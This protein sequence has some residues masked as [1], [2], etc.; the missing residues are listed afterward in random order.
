[1]FSQDG[2]IIDNNQDN[3]VILNFPKIRWNK[4]TK[5]YLECI[6]IIRSTSA[7]R[8]YFWNSFKK[9]TWC[10]SLSWINPLKVDKAY[11]N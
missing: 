1:M 9:N 10:T 5:K 2:P 6:L 11:Y 7:K 4:T 3:E 8:I